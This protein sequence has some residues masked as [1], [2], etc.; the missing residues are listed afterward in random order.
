M[1]PSQERKLLVKWQGPFEV[2]GKL[3]PTTYEISMSGKDCP[4]RI[5]HINLIMQW[6]SH[7]D[8]SAHIL[9]IKQVKEE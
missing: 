9:M 3:G 6:V 8:K 5:L 1:L 4:S 7:P 2:K